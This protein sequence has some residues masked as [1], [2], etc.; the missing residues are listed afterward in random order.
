MKHSSIPGDQD[1]CPAFELDSAPEPA[2]TDNSD[3]QLDSPPSADN[4]L[5]EQAQG[6]LFLPDYDLEPADETQQIELDGMQKPVFSVH[7]DNGQHAPFHN[8]NTLLE[9]L[10]AQGIDIQY[11]CREGYCG[12]CR[13][14]L[15]EG[16]VHYFEEPMAFI[17]DDEILPCCCVPK[18]PLS[19]KIPS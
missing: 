11:Q 12:S 14:K 10:E 16:Q 9:S 8:A 6:E 2:V 15:L 1:D 7:L 5:I 18:T 4:E 17:D 13:V 3:F 19:L